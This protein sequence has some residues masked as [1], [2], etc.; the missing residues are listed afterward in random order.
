MLPIF[1]FF[2]FSFYLYVVIYFDIFLFFYISIWNCRSVEI[3]TEAKLS[4][5]SFVPTSYRFIVTL[6]G[7]NMCCCDFGLTSSILFFL[8]CFCF[9][10]LCEA[11]MQ[12][13]V[14]SAIDEV[15]KY[16]P[17]WSNLKTEQ[18]N[19]IPPWRFSTFNNDDCY[20]GNN[21]VCFKTKHY[22]CVCVS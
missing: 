6:S 21:L 19:L 2:F 20:N 18:F 10:N 8:F 3:L 11:K 12:L 15:D 14:I 5:L 9:F 16:C 1:F 13:P 17:D 4:T 22:H 7:N